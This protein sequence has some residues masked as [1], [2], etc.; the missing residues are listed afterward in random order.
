MWDR[1]RGI[2]GC[3]ST[4]KLFHGHLGHRKTLVPNKFIRST[5]DPT[6]RSDTL[7]F[8]ELSHPLLTLA[9]AGV[10]SYPHSHDSRLIRSGL[11]DHLFRR[12]LGQCKISPST[13]DTGYDA[14]Q[15]HRLLR[16]YWQ[17]RRKTLGR[18]DP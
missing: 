3:R 6:S 1:K 9:M 17:G 16:Q 8:P 13:S 4:Q 11:P 15:T 18:C 7:T 5:G 10:A 2:L 14:R 12:Y